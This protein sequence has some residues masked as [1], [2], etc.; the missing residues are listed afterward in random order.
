M[1]L[2]LRCLAKFEYPVYSQVF[3]VKIHHIAY[4]NAE[5][6]LKLPIG[7]DLWPWVWQA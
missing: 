3:G 1:V 5:E 2:K 7:L 6:V 4:Y